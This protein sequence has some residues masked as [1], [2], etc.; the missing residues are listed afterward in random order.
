METIFSSVLQYRAFAHPQRI[1]YIFEGQAFTY[2]DYYKQAAG[3][4]NYLTSLGLKKGDLIGILDLNT[5]P[6]VN[7]ISGAMLIGVIPVSFNWRAM[8][9]EITFMLANAGISHFFY[10][11]AFTQ[12]IQATPLTG[13]DLHK[14]EDAIAAAE[15]ITSTE[16]ISGDDTCVILYTSGTTGL[17]KG[18]NI[19]YQNIYACYQLCAWDTPSFGP[20]C[21][22]LVCGPL[23]SIF[24]FGAF[25][26]CIYAG[27]TNVLA[28]M[29][30]P[31]MVAKIMSATKVTNALLVPIM[32]KLMTM[33][34]GIEKLDFSVLRHIQYG[35]SPIATDTL[36]KAQSL[37]NCYFTQVYGLTES[38]GVGC[39]LRFDDHAAILSGENIT[40]NELLFSAGKPAM[41]ITMKIVDDAGN[42]LPA[43]EPGEVLF[44][45]ENIAS[46]Y[47]NSPADNKLMFID[48]G[49]LASGDI[50]FVNEQGYLFL[51][52]RK[53]DKIVS[54]GVNIFPAEIERILEQHPQV[55]ESAIIAI[56]DDKAGEA[57]CAVI[58][59]KEGELELAALQ[60]WC[61]GKIADYK[62]PKQLVIKTELPRNPTGKI[63]R[64]LIREPFW[65]DE[66][67]NIKG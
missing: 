44:K 61:K 17:P 25:F 4:A 34:E 41:G 47:W 45:G 21:R 18:V 57:V 33:V 39:S 31:N 37:F 29:F 52:D 26:S 19:S 40:T 8:P 64:R 65:K 10:G 51:I 58:V 6:A 60:E 11:A 59:L 48:G 50:G 5:P 56:P 12:L 2:N 63:L 54:K 28:R 15:D 66:G 49:W 62:I 46:G 36:L 22:N 24:G 7:L 55:R 38:T 30:E 9:S 14:T 13:I 27:A 67:R 53:N 1:A 43:G 32:I 42:T 3:V 23:F 20:D 35:G 16:V